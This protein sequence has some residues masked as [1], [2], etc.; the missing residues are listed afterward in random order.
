MVPGFSVSPGTPGHPRRRA[1]MSPV[2]TAP[3]ACPAQVGEGWT[4][5]FFMGTANVGCWRASLSTFLVLELI[6]LTNTMN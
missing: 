4:L 6:N 3:E 5:L 2:R 1:W